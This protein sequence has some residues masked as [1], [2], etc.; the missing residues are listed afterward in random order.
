MTGSP[1]YCHD[2]AVEPL[3]FDYRLGMAW[4]NF[5]TDTERARWR[6]RA[7]SARPV[8]ARRAYKQALRQAD[9]A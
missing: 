8:D 3:T 7:G 2:G 4:W 9:V 5:F 6:A 1:A